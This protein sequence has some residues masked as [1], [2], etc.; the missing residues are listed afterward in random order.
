MRQCVFLLGCVVAMCMPLCLARVIEAQC[1]NTY[2]LD[3]ACGGGAGT[4]C[5]GLTQLICPTVDDYVRQ[6]NKWQCA[7]G[8]DNFQC[9]DSTSV[10]VCYIQSDCEWKTMPAPAHCS[11]V[12]PV[13]HDDVLKKRISC[14][15]GS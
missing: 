14:G 12:N 2:E 7:A 15:S 9:V 8:L 3:S 1:P 13:N 6:P 11:A 4:H 5:N 10:A